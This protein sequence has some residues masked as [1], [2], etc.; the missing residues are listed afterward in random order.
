MISQSFIQDLLDRVDIVDVIEREVP[1]KKAGTNYSAC[2]PFH[3]EK[4]PSFTVSPTKQFYHC[5]GCSAHGNAIGF[6]M[7]YSGMSFVEAV[8]DL[9]ARVGMQVPAQQSEPRSGATGA[10]SQSAESQSVLA[11]NQ[12]QDGKNSLQDLVG[13]MDAAGRFYRQQLRSSKVAIAYLKK[14]G[15]TGKTAA[16]FGIGYAP[17]GWQ[18]LDAAFSDPETQTRTTLLVNAGLLIRND[19]GKCY[20]RFRDRIMF[21]ILNLKGML[22]GFGG[23]VLEQ[24]EPKYL[25]S[26]E[27]PLF[28]KGRELYNLFDARRAIRQAGRVIVV[29]GYMDV[30]ALAQHGVEY[31]VA[32]LGTAVT[33]FHVQKLL[34]QTDDVVFC[35]DGDN[36][37]RK[38]A[39]RALE[40][41]LGQL[42][43]GKN[44]SFLFLPE[45]ED[46]DSYIRNFG[47]EAFEQLSRQSLPLSIFLFRELSARVDLKTSEGRAKL[48]QDAKPLLSRV[49]AP[50]LALML[51]KQLAE[52]SGF[53]QRE[54]ED[55]LKIRR[56]SSERARERAPRPKPASPYRWLMQILL[57]DPN[58][59]RKLER[60]LLIQDREYGDEIAALTALVEFIDA[61]PHIKENTAIPSAIAYFHESPH[62]I[63][64]QKAESE[65]LTWDSDIDLEAEFSGAMARLRDMKRKQRMTNLQNKSLSALTPE[66][67]QEL[68]RLAVS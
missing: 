51:L 58:H 21:P 18:N 44:V 62:G 40:D 39:W 4:T 9:A 56:V 7:E 63:L 32:T 20:S 61:H 15:L 26:P 38:A 64:L 2:C 1:L 45:G 37:G 55:L 41:S 13:V 42:V 31:V 33:P 68:Q 29:E 10:E 27:T 57:H 12:S 24:G 16:R 36:A 11:Q 35:F 8:N 30:V 22:V 19:D 65:T 48:V 67:K 49:A 43:D 5:F 53:T 54:L 14:R 50:G 52:I 34:R 23:R 59:I 6:L 66:E 17:T 28:Q 47:K 46:P 60:E 3:S 25:N